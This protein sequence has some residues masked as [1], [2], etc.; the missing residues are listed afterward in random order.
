[1]IWFNKSMGY[2]DLLRLL[3]VIVHGVSDS[4]AEFN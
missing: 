2:A 1:M 4:P 3:G